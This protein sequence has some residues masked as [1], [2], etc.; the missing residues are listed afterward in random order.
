[1]RFGLVI[2]TIVMVLVVVVFGVLWPMTWGATSGKLLKELEE[3]ASLG[4]DLGSVE[5]AVSQHLAQMQA[6]SETL[7]TRQSKLDPVALEA[8]GRGGAASA[9]TGQDAGG[10]QGSVAAAKA[11]LEAESSKMLEDLDQAKKDDWPKLRL[12]GVVTAGDESLAL[13]NYEVYRLGGI[14]KGVKIIEIREEE[15]VLASK[16]G[17]TRVILLQGWQ[18]KGTLK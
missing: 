9:V 17:E 12:L 6:L 7:K 5:N 2:A 1:M 4:S 11:Q 16:L 14:V 10:S 13:I 15:I 3:K 18:M 8:L